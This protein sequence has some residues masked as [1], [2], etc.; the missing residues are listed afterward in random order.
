MSSA[1]TGAWIGALLGFVSFVALRFVAERI[2]QGKSTASDSKRAATAIRLAGFADLLLF[3]VMGYFI[4]PL[5][6]DA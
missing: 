5:V 1:M 4:G 6:L 2:E 3:P